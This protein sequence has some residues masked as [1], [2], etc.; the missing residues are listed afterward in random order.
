MASTL[1]H[2]AP[3]EPS[4]LFEKNEFFAIEYQNN[5][6][7]HLIKNEAMEN[8]FIRERLLDCIQVF[9]DYF[10]KTIMLRQVFCEDQ[11]FLII[12]NQ[13]LAEEFGHNLA[14]LK[15][16]NNRPPLWDPVLE[17]TSSWFAWKILMLSN[18]EKTVLVHLV[19]ETSAN[20]FFQA[21]HKVMC[22]YGETDYF[23]IHS[24]ADEKHEQMGNNLIKNI[25]FDELGKL[26]L[27]QQQGWDMLNATCTQIA[28][29]TLQKGSSNFPA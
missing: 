6:L 11:N 13:H 1:N 17:A 3:I 14:L 2:Y 4:L 26:L 24:E 18:T 25:S 7:M 15:D 19:L 28:T 23:K 20:I 16:R 5:P 12:A 29:L 27:I 22:K 10:Q 9:S 8:K 21:A